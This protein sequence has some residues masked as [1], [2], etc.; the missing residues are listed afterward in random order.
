[1]ASESKKKIVLTVTADQLDMLEGFYTAC[2]W[3]F[4]PTNPNPTQEGMSSCFYVTFIWKTLDSAKFLYTLIYFYAMLYV[5]KHCY[6]R[7]DTNIVCS[8]K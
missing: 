3:T 7:I 6:T 5:Y 8:W 2:G 1:M 4:Q